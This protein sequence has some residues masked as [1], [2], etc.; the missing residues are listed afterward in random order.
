MDL[1]R[2]L[3][4]SSAALVLASSLAAAA[5]AD[6]DV[7]VRDI[8][9]APVVLAQPARRVISLAP[10]LTELMFA[11]GA[12]DRIVGTVEYADFPAQARRLPRVGDSALLDLERIV[13]LQPD[14]LLVWRH[15]NSPQ[16]L[17]RLAALHVPTYASE[18]R[19]LADIART[20]RD[21][22]ALAGSAAMAE[23][24][25][26]AFEG[27]VA[28]LRAQHRGQRRLRVF[29]QIWDQPLI[30]INGEHL[31][32]QVLDVCGADNVFAAQRLLTPTV[33]AEAVVWADPDAIVAGWSDSYG[34]SGPLAAWR[35][36][37]SMRA[38]RQGHLLQVDPDLLHRQSDRVI[39]GARELCDKL[40]AVRASLGR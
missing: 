20:L 30:T 38:V 13:A 3:S 2:R 17:E 35:P 18:A 11:V 26:T 12:G 27:A 5:P 22:G 31:I 6:A 21:L 23:A 29:Y 28:E 4:A 36:L 39:G 1:R 8:D 24:R 34:G 40:D 16:Q 7:R 9:G 19:S 25:A 37:Q 14:L 15:G 33:S 10:H 32:S